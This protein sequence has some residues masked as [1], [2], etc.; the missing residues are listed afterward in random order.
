M[1]IKGSDGLFGPFA[2]LWDAVQDMEY[3]A[4][5]D[6]ESRETLEEAEAGIGIA[7]WVDGNG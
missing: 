1:A 3:N 5:T 2:T 4:E 6:I 7:D